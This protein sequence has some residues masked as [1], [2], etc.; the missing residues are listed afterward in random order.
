VINAGESRLS[1]QR[2]TWMSHPAGPPRADASSAA[3]AVL[4][5]VAFGHFGLRSG[6]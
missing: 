6:G 2:L 3:S 1:S 4:V 5:D